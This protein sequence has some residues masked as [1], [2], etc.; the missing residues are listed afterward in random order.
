MNA[1]KAKAISVGVRQIMPEGLILHFY[2]RMYPMMLLYGF[3]IIPPGRMFEAAS[4]KVWS[5]ILFDF[6]QL[7]IYT[8]SIAL[9]RIPQENFFVETNPRDIL[10]VR[11]L[12]TGMAS[13]GPDE[14]PLFL[15]DIFEDEGPAQLA[16]GGKRAFSFS[17]YFVGSTSQKGGD[18]YTNMS[19]SNVDAEFSSRGYGDGAGSEGFTADQKRNYM[20]NRNREAQ[21]PPS[22]LAVPSASALAA[23]SASA[24]PASTSRSLTVRGL[25]PN[26]QLAVLSMDTSVSDRIISASPALAAVATDLARRQDT[27]EGVDL[28]TLIDFTPE[29]QQ[30][31]LTRLG[32][33]VENTRLAQELAVA[34]HC[35]AL[36]SAGGPFSSASIGTFISKMREQAAKDRAFVE[37]NLE[38]L[39]ARNFT[40]EQIQ[41]LGDLS[42]DMKRLL[43]TSFN[44]LNN[45]ETRFGVESARGQAEMTQRETRQFFLQRMFIP[46]TGA[47]CLLFAF[48]LIRVGWSIF[49][50]IFRQAHA[51][52]ITHL[53]STASGTMAGEEA[54]AASAWTLSGAFDSALWAGRQTLTFTGDAV[55]GAAQMAV[56]TITYPL[57]WM[58]RGVSRGLFGASPGNVVDVA[59]AGASQA[60]TIASNM[61]PLVAALVATLIS[62]YVLYYMTSNTMIYVEASSNLTFI[63]RRISRVFNRLRAFV[64]TQ[65]VARYIANREVAL[66]SIQETLQRGVSQQAILQVEQLGGL[67]GLLRQWETA[68]G[69][70]L[71]SMSVDALLLSVPVG[72]LGTLREQAALEFQHARGRMG[73]VTATFRARMVNLAT[74]NTTR[75]LRSDPTFNLLMTTGNV[76]INTILG[77]LRTGGAAASSIGRG[78]A[79]AGRSGVRLGAT[80]AAAYATSKGDP[81]LAAAILSATG[82]SASGAAPAS[83][84]TAASGAA[85]ASAG[86]NAAGL[87]SIAPPEVL[88]AVRGLIADVPDEQA[89]VAQMNS[90]IVA[91]QTGRPS[92]RYDNPADMNNFVTFQRWY[93]AMMYEQ[94]R[95]A[96][97]SMPRAQGPRGGPVIEE[98]NNNATNSTSLVPF[99]R[100]RRPNGSNGG[101]FGGNRRGKS[102]KHTK[103]HTKKTRKH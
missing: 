64:L 7:L 6:A 3:P 69:T 81:S 15:K 76:G 51:D 61:L 12:M 44:L 20:R 49:P 2:E 80:A 66:T 53:N 45:I 31:V 94:M 11:L 85:P 57:S 79:S 56:G 21:A 41:R 1:N 70:S 65:I 52:T 82:T 17:D 5:E 50:G 98:L 14:L 62:T 60:V 47:A 9:K 86:S 91:A 37:R 22:A 95:M 13:C 90:L 73:E 96:T 101:P 10:V 84:G 33:T 71:S 40:P 67:E 72:E 8:Y 74:S 83:A 68:F 30:A 38:K 24:R 19:N 46:V 34:S 77:V 39:S 100:R 58:G 78:I 35:N 89:R 55:S 42:E 54:A 63:E 92:I 28:T 23:S 29:Q 32:A 48:C 75:Q 103:K 102:R 59:T 88:G 27:G 43:I 87:A 18:R 97:F 99:L 16:G 93:Q 36:V 25:A 26:S 4:P